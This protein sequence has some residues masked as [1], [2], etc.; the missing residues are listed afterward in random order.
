MDRELD[1]EAVLLINVGGDAISKVVE[2]F[3]IESFR[4]ELATNGPS[5]YPDLFLRTKDYD[6]WPRFVRIKKGD[7]TEYGAALKG[8]SKRP[9]RVPDGLEV[10]TCKGKFNVDCHHGHAG[11]H[12]AVVYHLDAVGTVVDDVLVA[13]MRLADYR[14]TKPSTATTTLK[15]S[16]NG[17][18]F[19]SLL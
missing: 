2:K 17:K 12:L 14:I 3:L 15:A 8:T 5:D 6:Q 9:V 13:F 1:R 7:S 10:K 19:V 16:F 18:N 4:G 11:L